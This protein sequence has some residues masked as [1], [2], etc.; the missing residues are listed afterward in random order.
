MLAGVRDDL[1]AWGRCMGALL[2]SVHQTMASVFAKR[3]KA[4]ICSLFKKLAVCV[5]WAL[6]SG[7][8]AGAAPPESLPRLLT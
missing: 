8:C 1:V 5:W 2:D 4:G 7:F 6:P 3:C